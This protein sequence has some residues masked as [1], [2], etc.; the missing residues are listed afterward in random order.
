MHDFLSG[1]SIYS[2][3]FYQIALAKSR[4]FSS[5]HAIFFVDSTN[6]FVQ[7]GAPVP[8]FWNRFHTICK[9]F[10]HKKDCP[11]DGAV[12]FTP[13]RACSFLRCHCYENG[14]LQGTSLNGS[15]C[16]G[17]SRTPSPTWLRPQKNPIIR[18][19]QFPQ[20]FIIR[21][22]SAPPRTCGSRTYEGVGFSGF[23]TA[24]SPRSTCQ[25]HDRFL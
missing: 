11:P 9:N 18:R 1:I 4:H 8:E 7:D 12:S 22:D 15:A 10:F 6:S 14:D 23:L 13:A 20:L 2:L 17:T 16:T 3:M 24:G 5:L 19:R 25:W 21:P